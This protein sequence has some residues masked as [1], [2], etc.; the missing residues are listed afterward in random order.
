MTH[1]DE[2]AGLREVAADDRDVRTA[3]RNHLAQVAALLPRCQATIARSAELLEHNAAL[4]EQLWMTLWQIRMDRAAR[5]NMPPVERDLDI[6][7]ALTAE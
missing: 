1:R 4:Q 2:G 3:E 6:G 7:T 5:S